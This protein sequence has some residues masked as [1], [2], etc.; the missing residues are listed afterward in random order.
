MHVKV[1][2]THDKW[3]GMT[4][5]EDMPEIKEA[6]ADMN[7]KGIYNVPLFDAREEMNVTA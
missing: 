7:R 6:F 4:H 3:Y 2:P 1:I 5:T